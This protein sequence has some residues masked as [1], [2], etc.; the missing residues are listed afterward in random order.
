ME[1]SYKRDNIFKL[2]IHIH[3][4][5]VVYVSSFIVKGLGMR[6]GERRL[7]RRGRKR[8]EEEEEGKDGW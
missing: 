3:N 7:R 4:I 5:C 2:Y 6:K 1:S 8:E